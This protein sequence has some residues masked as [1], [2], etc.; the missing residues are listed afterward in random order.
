MGFQ[1]VADLHCHT[2]ASTHAYS[3]VGELAQAAASQG[4]SAVACTDHGPAPR[5][6]PTFGILPICMCFP[7]ICPG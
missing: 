4:L 7:L 5:M 1:P 6:R 2:V 3:T